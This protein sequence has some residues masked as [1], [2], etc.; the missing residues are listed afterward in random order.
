MADFGKF[1]GL[2]VMIPGMVI[3]NGFALMMLWGWFVAPLFKAP[4]MPLVNAIGF[5]IVVRLL[6]V[7]QSDLKLG[8]AKESDAQYFARLGYSIVYIA[9]ALGF[10]WIVA[11]FV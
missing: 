9:M 5:A 7:T 2:I 10:G 6:T 3:F 4:E 8:I 1:I 11:D